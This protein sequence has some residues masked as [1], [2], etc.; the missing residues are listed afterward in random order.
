MRCFA[1]M[2]VF[3][4]YCTPVKEPSL[5]L[6]LKNQL[7]VPQRYSFHFRQ[8]PFQSMQTRLGYQHAKMQTDRWFLFN[9]F[10]LLTLTK[11]EIIKVQKLHGQSVTYQIH[12][13][14]FLT[15]E[16]CSKCVNL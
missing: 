11:L 13:F 15:I 1:L 6:T 4:L 9:R 16:V 3:S 5:L 10:T 8:G 12:L 14:G 2:A 7:S